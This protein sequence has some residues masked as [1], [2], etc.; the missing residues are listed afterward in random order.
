MCPKSLDH[1]S[2][3]TGYVLV[4]FERR[5]QAIILKT[6]SYRLHVVK[7]I[8]HAAGDGNRT[9]ERGKN[10]TVSYSTSQGD[11]KIVAIDATYL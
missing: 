3:I 9:R 10:P 1:E 11:V 4:A 2:G 5:V 7:H 6:N 8:K